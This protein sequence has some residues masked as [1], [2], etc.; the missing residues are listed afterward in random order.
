[1][2]ICL[3]FLITLVQWSASVS[4]RKHFGEWI[5]YTSQKMLWKYSSFV[6]LLLYLLIYSDFSCH[7]HSFINETQL[8][9]VATLGSVYTTWSF[10]MYVLLIFISLYSSLEAKTNGVNKLYK[11]NLFLTATKAQKPKFICLASQE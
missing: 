2:S 4:V 8:L 7:W 9:A 6:F 3:N 11:T 10:K 5:I 1:M